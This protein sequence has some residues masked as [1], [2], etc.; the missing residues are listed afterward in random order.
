MSDIKLLP[1]P[2][3]NW[4]GERASQGYLEDLQYYA[5]QC[6]LAD[7]AERAETWQPI[8]TAPMDGTQI[9]IAA[10]EDGVVFDLCNGH[11]EVLA[12]DE[13]DGTWDI[14]DGEPWCSYQGRSAGTY[15]C[16]WLPG[17]EWETRC[18]VEESFEYTHWMPLP[19][20]PT[21][22]RGADDE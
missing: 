13:D 1:L 10:I 20:A 9:V 5:R 6:V 8:A 2:Q 14:R 18:R 19:A 16:L 7:R 12:E 17:K 15:F 22:E 4:N 3:R 21:Q 11:F